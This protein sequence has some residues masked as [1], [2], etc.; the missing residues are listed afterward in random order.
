[1]SVLH[2]ISTGG[3]YGAERMLFDHVRH[4]PARTRHSVVFIDAPESV[5]RKFAEA[6]IDCC[7]APSLGSLVRTCRSRGLATVL[8]C[9]GYKAL[10]YAVAG[11][12]VHRRPLVATLHGFTPVSS[13]KRFYA[14]L[15]LALCRLPVVGRVVCVSESIAEL[16][17]Q[18][19]VSAGKIVVLPNA[20][21]APPPAANPVPAEAMPTVASGPLVGFIGRLRSEKGP[22]LFLECFRSIRKALPQVRAVVLGDGPDRELLQERVRQLG[23]GDVV[24]MLGYVEDVSP[25][26]ERFDVILL[27][28]RTEGTPMVLL[29]AMQAGTPIAA[30][31]VGGVTELLEG[32]R[33]G[34]LAVPGDVEGLA[35]QAV[36]VLNE[37]GLRA[38]LTA[39]ART[40]S[41][42]RYGIEQCAARWESLY[43]AVGGT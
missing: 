15:Y 11:A 2:L 43:R 35:R 14:W 38:S 24:R 13:K 6:G 5:V 25:W 34:L 12:L 28:S 21:A 4:A 8:N 41:S 9:H 10:A 29:E 3:F 20:I 32:G 33:C 22:D 17:R 1:M 26:L 16:A 36:R 18:T 40:R 42:G 23:L 19:K 37:P 27:S 30:F 39:A 7:R 31:S